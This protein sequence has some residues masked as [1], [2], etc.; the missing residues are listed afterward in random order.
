MNQASLVPSEKLHGLSS[1]AVG[2][3]ASVT[4]IDEVR[5]ALCD[6]SLVGKR[7]SHRLVSPLVSMGTVT[8]CWSCR[9]AALSEGYRPAD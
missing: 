2:E 8:V 7:E 6:A 1:S 5:C 4:P 9:R 3:W